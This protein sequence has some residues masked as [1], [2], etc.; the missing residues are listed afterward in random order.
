MEQE[1][2]VR[3]L[4][5]ADEDGEGYSVESIAAIFPAVV[6]LWTLMWSFCSAFLVMMGYTLL[7]GQAAFD[8][9]QIAGGTLLLTGIAVGARLLRFNTR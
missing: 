4:P 3:E 8:I 9:K 6:V 5:D 2:T 1:P 7:T